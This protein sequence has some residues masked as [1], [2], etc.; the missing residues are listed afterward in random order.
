MSDALLLLVNSFAIIPGFPHK[1]ICEDSHIARGYVAQSISPIESATTIKFEIDMRA[2]DLQPDRRFRI[3]G[4]QECAILFLAERGPRE[5]SEVMRES[6]CSADEILRLGNNVIKTS[7]G[8][9]LAVS[10]ETTGVLYEIGRLSPKSIVVD[11]ADS[12]VTS[13]RIARMFAR[14]IEKVGRM[15][16]VTY[17]IT[18][19]RDEFQ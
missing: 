5:L 6:S 10:S 17:R 11:L 7:P 18:D 4:H 1:L 19:A 13:R 2:T 3:N 12:V 9:A 15:G 8:E 16:Y 14:D